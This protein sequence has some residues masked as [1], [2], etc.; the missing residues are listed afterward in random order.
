[1]QW[2]EEKREKNSQLVENWPPKL[3]ITK[4]CHL[5][6]GILGLAQG[7]VT[8]QGL[9]FGLGSNLIQK[10]DAFKIIR[11]LDINEAKTES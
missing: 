3:A 2:I 5:G 7:I 6:Y 10:W 1:M 9:G 4:L 8:G 11:H